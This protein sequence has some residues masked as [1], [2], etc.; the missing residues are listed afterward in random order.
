VTVGDFESSSGAPVFF[1]SFRHAR[2]GQ[3]TEK[4]D[5]D[6]PVMELF[7]ALSDNVS[8]LLG[9]LPG[10]D[11][12][13][14]DRSMAGGQRWTR[15]LFRAA[16]SC[17]VFVPL[18]SPRLLQSAWCGMEWGLF[19][20]RKVAR[21]GGGEPTETGIL[22]VTWIPTDHNTVPKVIADVLPFMPNGLPDGTASAYTREGLLGMRKLGADV[23]YNAIV[24][25]LAQRIVEISRSHHVV[26]RKRIP[27]GPAHLRNVFLSAKKVP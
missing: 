22:P 14:V 24:W 4:G 2:T 6:Q 9:R 15:E 8:E 21:I 7:D 27:R 26:P 16:S 25:R 13:F 3:L 19:A 5:P 23:A 10:E 12:G 18:V 20:Q 1:L 11:A 17:Q